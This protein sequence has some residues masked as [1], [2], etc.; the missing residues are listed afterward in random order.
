VTKQSGLGMAGLVGGYDLSGDIMSFSKI[1]GSKAVLDVTAIN[2]SAH[3]R[4]TGL[5]DGAV[6]F[7]S[8]FDPSPGQ[9]HPVLAALPRTDV[10]VMGCINL[11]VGG[12]AACL[13]A[14]QLDYNPNRQNT[15]MLDAAVSSQANGFGLE[16][17]KLLTPGVY[18]ATNALTGQ[19]A[20]FEG[21]IGN[22]TALTNCAVAGSS[23]QAHSGAN[24]M[25]MTSAAAGDMV[26]ESCAAASI[27]T[28]GFAVVPG[29]SVQVQAWLRTAVSARTASVGVHWF[30]SGGASV[31]TT[32]GT[33][34]AD[35]STT[36][37]VESGTLTAPATAAYGCVSVKVSA[38]GGASEVHYV[39]DVQVL[40]LPVSYDS[41]ASL[42]FGAQAYLQVTAFTGT[43][44]T[45]QIV[46]S[47]DNVT[48]AAVAGL[49][50]TQVTAAPATQRLAISNTATVRRYIGVQ[51]TTVGGFTALS[52][53]LAINKNPIAG[54]V[55]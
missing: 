30:T 19:N 12:E 33:G 41:G 25:S 43:D 6:D 49:G 34:A 46:D 27:A 8:A 35:S 21:G 18:T 13:V 20:G 54:Q 4:I 44:A 55:F 26:A 53:A 16:W 36:W 52:F 37:T 38:T 50:F 48:F 40:V 15:G 7:T 39:D 29:Q 47:A 31:S 10:H 28:Q 32:Y 11:T 2:K 1:S 17:A 22:W 51:V 23:A 9:S 42:S 24:S 14:K 3:E 45:I 5:R